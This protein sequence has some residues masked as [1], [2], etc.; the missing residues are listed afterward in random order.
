M[1]ASLKN[2]PSKISEIDDF[3]IPNARYFDIKKVF[4]DQY[5]HLPNMLPSSKQ[6]EIAAQELGI[7]KDSQ[8]VVYDKQ[9]IYTSPRAWWMCQNDGT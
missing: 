6:F 4:S 9:G 1:D 5:S 3:Q 2:K 7:N 8:I